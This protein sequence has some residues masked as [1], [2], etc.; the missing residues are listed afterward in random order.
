MSLI[1]SDN[2]IVTITW[3][4]LCKKNLVQF[5]FKKALRSNHVSKPRVITVNKNPAYPIAIE[6]LK[7]EKS[8]PDDMQ[9]RQRKYLNNIVEQDYRFIKKWIRSMLGLKTFGTV[10]QIICCVEVMHMLKKDNFPKG[11]SLSKARLNSY[12]DYL[13]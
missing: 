1:Q 7:K 13:V 9:I 5:F 8:I 2:K 6:Q 3:E 4:T 12:I 11:W 10:K